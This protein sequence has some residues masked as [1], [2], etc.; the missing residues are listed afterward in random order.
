MTL[1]ER[2]LAKRKAK[3]NAYIDLG[4]GDLLLDAG[5]EILH[6]EDFGSY[7]GDF[8]FLVSDGKRKGLLIQGYGSCSGCDA[9][10]DA[11]PWDDDGDFTNLAALRD[12]MV[13]SIVWAEPGRLHD[14]F[15]ERLTSKDADSWWR[16][17]DDQAKAKA[18]TLAYEADQ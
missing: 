4:Y 18:L 3:D 16:Y 15:Q 10:L 9:L 8:V 6:S 5:L 13:S 12:S 14:T 2:L 7:Q 1:R 17:A 11:H